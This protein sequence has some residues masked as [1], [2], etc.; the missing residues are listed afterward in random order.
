[1]STTLTAGQRALIE[2][3]LRMRLA[4]LER[5]IAA[6]QEGGSRPEHASSFLE[7]DAD[8]APQRSA[9]RE[10]D[11]ALSDAEM[12]E[13][14]RVS[15]ALGRLDDADFGFCRQCGVQI[16]F[17]RLKIE[18]QAVRCVACESAAEADAG[19]PTRSTL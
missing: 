19:I 15:S 17:D 4:E 10:V 1:M 3:A 6:R 7:Q 11:L 9:D 5:Q 13:L 14:G 8:D 2:N 12:Q 16:P 18:P